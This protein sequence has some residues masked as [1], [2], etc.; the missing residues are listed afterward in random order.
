MKLRCKLLIA[1][2]LFAMAA[3][4]SASAQG[5]KWWQS[6][7]FQQTLGLTA[8]QIAR[9]E[10][11][12][13]TAEPALRAEKQ[14]LD[15][16]EEKLSKVIADPASDEAAVM[17]ACEKVDAARNELSR[18]RT[19]MLFRMRRVLSD[20]QNLQMKQMHERDRSR[21]GRPRGDHPDSSGS[22]PR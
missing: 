16:L 3:A 1:L 21:G 22:F 7:R 9:L 5:F 2:A 15:R 13:Q 19:L 12:Y 14:A 6:Q 18:S 20:E 4:E 17:A 8:E 11:L 10:G